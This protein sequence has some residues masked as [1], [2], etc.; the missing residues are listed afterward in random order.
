MEA[1][2]FATIV[3]HCFMDFCTKGWNVTVSK[4]FV[5]IIIKTF[6]KKNNETIKQ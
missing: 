4:F 6:F 5:Y 3:G 2:H 1:Q